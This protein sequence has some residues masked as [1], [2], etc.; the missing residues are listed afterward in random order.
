MTSRERVAADRA[1]RGRKRLALQRILVGLTAARIWA[2][3]RRFRRLCVASCLIVASPTI[4]IAAN[5]RTPVV[6]AVAR[7]SPAVVSVQVVRMVAARSSPFDAFFR[8][9]HPRRY[10]QQASQGSGVIISAQGYV[11]TNYH[12][13]AVGGD[14]QL[15][16]TDGRQFSAEVVGS[17]PDHDLAVL[18]INTDT[19]LPFVPMGQSGDLLIGE[20]VIAIGNPFGLAHTV[21]TGVISAV[22]R[23]IEA[24]G[25]T[26]FDFIQ[27]DASINPGNSGGALLNIQGSLIGVNT[28]VYGRAQGIGF[29][30]PIDKAR[31]IVD[32]LLRYGEVRRPYFGFETQVLTPAL[33]KSFGL[34]SGRGVVVRSIERGGPADGRLRTGDVLRAIDNY[35]I[36]EPGALRSRL[37]DYTVGQR[38]RF[39]LQRDGAK[40]D[41]AV[42]A[43][44]LTPNEAMNRLEGQVG[45]TVREM[46]RNDPRGLP[47]GAIVIDRVIPG[48]VAARYRLRV[49]DWVRAVS[50]RRVQGRKAFALAVAESYWRGELLLLI[51]RGRSWQQMAFPF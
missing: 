40:V 38:A 34:E 8:D 25:R 39:R 10:Q 5:R 12:V 45:L 21:T 18:K 3:T 32:D 46:G 15:E 2:R 50:S 1:M 22:G 9:F 23:T 19:R 33:A 43:A 14:I 42:T 49:G 16:L 44:A 4:G 17:S 36:A 29:A 47:V 51:Q 7:T 48:S 11:L 31:R 37:G 41:V 13:I 26:Y 27:T 35:P 6:E 24:E 20:T 30:I 28:A